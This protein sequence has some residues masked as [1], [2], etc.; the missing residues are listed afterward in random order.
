MHGQVFADSH[1]RCGM[2]GVVVKVDGYF[3]CRNLKGIGLNAFVLVSYGT[4]L[5]RANILAQ[6]S[7]RRNT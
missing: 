5:H 1:G 6:L 3:M 2:R 4:V 7:G